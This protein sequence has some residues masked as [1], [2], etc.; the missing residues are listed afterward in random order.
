MTSS[1]AVN[2]FTNGVSEQNYLGIQAGGMWDQ[3]AYTPLTSINTSV[4][5]SLNH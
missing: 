4:S 5:F 2:I 3:S 1:R